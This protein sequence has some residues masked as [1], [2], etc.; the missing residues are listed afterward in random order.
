MRLLRSVDECLRVNDGIVL[1][2]FGMWFLAA[3]VSTN[4]VYASHLYLVSYAFHGEFN[5]S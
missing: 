3:I 5:K 4:N 2:A 1:T